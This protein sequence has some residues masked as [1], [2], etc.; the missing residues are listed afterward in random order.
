MSAIVLNTP[1]AVAL[2]FEIIKR[3]APGFRHRMLGKMQPI[4]LLSQL[5]GKKIQAEQKESEFLLKRL[6]ELKESLHLATHATVELFTWLNPDQDSVQPL[7]EIVEECL[8]LL[9]MDIYAS[10][11]CFQNTLSSTQPVKA[12]QIRNMFAACVLTY[13]DTVEKP[14]QVVISEQQDNGQLVLSMQIGPLA[15]KAEKEIPASATFVDWENVRLISE[16]AV[17][18]KKENQILIS[19]LV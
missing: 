9:K 19:N 15:D 16:G 5:I 12:S 11:I 3:L 14:A 18:S 7:S 2:R 6:Q 8:D 10:N 13:I 17:F 4:A 1:A